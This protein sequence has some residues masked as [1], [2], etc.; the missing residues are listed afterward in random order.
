[1]LANRKFG[2][3]PA[4]F[5]DCGDRFCV[6]GYGGGVGSVEEMLDLI[7][8]IE[9]CDGLELMSGRHVDE[10]NVRDVGRMFADR[11]LDVC[12]VVPDLWGRAEWAR[13]ALAAPDAPTRAAAADEVKRAMDLAAE[14]GC[15]HIDVWP[16]Q[17]GYDYCF[18][19]DY[20]QARNR[21]AD[22]LAQ[23]A[24]HN[25][26]VRILV[27]YKPK[28]PRKHCFV[29]SA[30]EVLLLLQGLDRVGVLLDVGHALQGGENMAEAAATLHHHG[31][32]DYI[33][34]N[35]NYRSWDDDLMVGSVHLVEYLELCYWLQRLDYGG[36]LTLDIYPCREDGVAAAIECRDWMEGFF[37]AVDRV[38]MDSFA[39]VIEE[40]NPCEA[41]KLVR[42]ALSL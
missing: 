41:S 32:L 3:G 33:H 15:P 42:R 8:K 21:L 17:D 7:V 40:A 4:L 30:A 36:W 19:A 6:S 9:G 1:M 11:G 12:M 35:D 16:G 25:P 10:K 31:K 20:V 27:E 34:L 24:E 22:G 29:S 2:V 37:K 38:G 26:N 18:Q 14:L 5:G 39:R 23:C 28:E 13:G